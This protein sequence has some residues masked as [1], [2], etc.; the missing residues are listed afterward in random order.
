MKPNW[1]D[2]FV[3]DINEH[4]A[5]L[6][7]THD[8]ILII[9][10]THL[11]VEQRLDRLLERKLPNPDAVLGQPYPRFIHKLRMLKALIPDPPLVHNLWDLITDL[12]N[13]R[14]DLAHKLTPKDIQG[15]I[16]DF[17]VKLF[18]SLDTSGGLNKAVSHQT[19]TYKIRVTLILLVWFLDYLR[20]QLMSSPDNKRQ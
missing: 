13:I 11:L 6:P 9:L 19:I 18:G 15:R 3:K 16:E 17:V 7:E 4:I 8:Q 12:N 1:V 2:D 10:K 5:Q 20:E 14:N